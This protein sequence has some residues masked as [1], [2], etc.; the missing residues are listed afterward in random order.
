MVESAWK[1]KRIPNQHTLQM[2]TT[3]PH[4]AFR[5]LV[6]LAGEGAT[7]KFWCVCPQWHRLGE[8]F[9]LPEP[10]VPEAS[11]DFSAGLWRLEAPVWQHD[12]ELRRKEGLCFL[13]PPKCLKLPIHGFWR[14]TYILLSICSDAMVTRDYSGHPVFGVFFNY[15]LQGVISYIG[16]SHLFKYLIFKVCSLCCVY[17]LPDKLFQ[18]PIILTAKKRHLVSRLNL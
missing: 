9:L 10:A 2:E 17:H 7:W 18:C 6:F 15:G 8:P 12:P 14:R 11:I 1:K 3:V 16:W 5:Q 13:L 4:A